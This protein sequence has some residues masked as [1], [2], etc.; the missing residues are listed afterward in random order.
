MQKE[1]DMTD[2]YIEMFNVGDI[3]RSLKNPRLTYKVLETGHINELNQK[4]YKVEIFTDGKAEES[5]NIKYIVCEKM[6]K[7]ADK[8]NLD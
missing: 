7:W 8:L 2:R 3:L 5:R 4:E 1:L 6:D